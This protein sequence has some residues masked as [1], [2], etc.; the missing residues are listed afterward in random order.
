MNASRP[1]RPLP[2]PA[3]PHPLR[4]CLIFVVSLLSI[5]ALVLVSGPAVAAPDESTEVTTS[6]TTEITEATGATTVETTEE[7]EPTAT[8]SPTTTEPTTTE[9]TT[10]EP[11]TTEPTTTTQPAEQGTLSVEAVYVNTGVHTPLLVD[12][13]GEQQINAPFQIQRDPGTVALR[14][15]SNP[16]HASLISP[17]PINAEIVA[18]QV[19]VVVFEFW[20]VDAPAPSGRLD[21][22]KR[23]RITGVGL[24]GAVFE[25]VA[26]ESGESYGTWETAADGTVSIHLPYGC[27]RALE[28]RAPAGY[29]KEGRFLQAQVLADEPG[30]I[31]V[32][33]TPRGHLGHRNPADRTPLRSIPSGPVY[34]P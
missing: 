29:L 4:R 34:H 5:T 31:V 30:V 1:A 3:R 26:C 12:I 27:Y 20:D 9:P 32:Y 25:V 22:V 18:G 13:G 23:D 21:L 8:T 28:R 10:T 24:A 7:T 15:A 17:I 11:T 16:P 14:P 2:Y 19:T 33:N 6:E